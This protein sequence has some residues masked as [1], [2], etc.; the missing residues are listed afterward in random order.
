LVHEPGALDGYARWG[1]PLLGHIALL[2]EGR[3]LPIERLL[4]IKPNN[5]L[6]YQKHRI[7]IYYAESWVFVHYLLFGRRAGALSDLNTY[8]SNLQ[9]GMAPDKAFEIAFGTDYAGMDEAL[10]EYVRDGRYS[11][12]M[13]DLP[14][15]PGFAA[16]F[17]PAAP[18]RVEAA[19]ARLASSAGRQDTARVHE[20]AARNLQ[21]AD[22][23]RVNR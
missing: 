16:P 5:P 9:Q 6:Y 3:Y 17:M 7:G 10:A 18:A 11:V 13:K 21:G 4:S 20:A 12:S 14:P 8:L 1:D 15:S 22:S 19:L 2:R 23:L